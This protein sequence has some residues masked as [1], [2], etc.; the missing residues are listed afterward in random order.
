[1][2][3]GQLALSEEAVRSIG[4]ADAGLG[5]SGEKAKR[6]ENREGAKREE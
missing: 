1:M 4:G 2:T 3:V 6:M 5:E